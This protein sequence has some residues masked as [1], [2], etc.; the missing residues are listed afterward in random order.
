M[1][2]VPGQVQTN[3][4]K[5]VSNSNTQE[6]QSYRPSSHGIS[7]RAQAPSRMPAKGFGPNPLATWGGLVPD[8]VGAW[9]QPGATGMS[10]AEA[11]ASAGVV[12][13]GAPL[14]LYGPLLGEGGGLTS[15]KIQGAD[16]GTFDGTVASATQRGFKV[17][18]AGFKEANEFYEKHPLR[19]RYKGTTREQVDNI[20]K[21]KGDEWVLKQMLGEDY[22]APDNSGNIQMQDIPTNIK[23]M[24]TEIERAE[25]AR[26]EHLQEQLSAKHQ[27]VKDEVLKEHEADLAQRKAAKEA[28]DE[29]DFRQAEIKATHGPNYRYKGPGAK[30]APK[31]VVPKGTEEIELENFGKPTPKK[32]P[33]IWGTGEP[34]IPG[35]SAYSGPPLPKTASEMFQEQLKPGMTKEELDALRT[36]VTADRK[37]AMRKWLEKGLEE[38]VPLETPGRKIGKIKSALLESEGELVGTHRLEGDKGGAA[39]TPKNPNEGPSKFGGEDPTITVDEGTE[40]DNLLKDRAEEQIPKRPPKP[41]KPG[42]TTEETT[43]EDVPGQKMPE[44]DFR[45]NIGHVK[46]II[47][48]GGVGRKEGVQIG[49]DRGV[50]KHPIGNDKPPVIIDPIIDPPFKPPPDDE[51]KDDEPKDY[52]TV[53]NEHLTSFWKPTKQRGS[54]HDWTHF[55]KDYKEGFYQ[56]GVIPR[57]KW[58]ATKDTNWDPWNDDGKPEDPQNGFAHYNSGRQLLS[59]PPGAAAS[60]L[61]EDNDM[62]A[63]VAKVAGTALASYLFGEYGPSQKETTDA[64]HSAIDQGYSGLKSA[65][66]K[67]YTSVTDYLEERER[68]KVIGQDYVDRYWDVSRDVEERDYDTIMQERQKYIDESDKIVEAEKQERQKHYDDMMEEQAK[69]LEQERKMKEDGE[70]IKQ[71]PKEL[72]YNWA[73]FLAP[74]IEEPEETEP[75]Q[76]TKLTDYYGTPGNRLKTF[77]PKSDSIN[78]PAIPDEVE[79]E[80]SVEPYQIPSG[81]MRDHFPRAGRRP[82][83]GPRKSMRDNYPRRGRRPRGGP[84]PQ[85]QP[86]PPVPPQPFFP[87]LAPE[88]P[89]PPQGGDDPIWHPEPH[90]PAIYRPL[91]Y[92]WKYYFPDSDPFGRHLRY[93]EDDD[94]DDSEISP[95]KPKKVTSNKIG[96]QKDICHYKH[97]TKRCRKKRKL[98]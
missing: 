85:P 38:D 88:N 84:L 58:D 39:I 22:V 81:S 50:D 25:K 2:L 15:G 20:K 1:G 8:V 53:T 67:G 54:F 76:E 64:I 3:S 61:S 29:E 94:D 43:I 26:K 68:Q 52:S 17:N 80:K 60:E 42:T 27:K 56:D 19:H 31:R 69:I 66:E 48:G 93:K 51:P 47:P 97:T 95:E 96:G 37:V 10:K 12:A 71:K 89:L 79:E 14:L 92:A 4:P 63:Q 18:E 57:E 65:M 83:G 36:K 28:K 34:A 87:N 13:F 7:K 33:S 98:S 82:I 78:L 32:T 11:A 9:K 59:W 77:T 44:D 45:P 70:I 23:E 49:V 75:I 21:S 41:S 16:A 6:F 40:I 46:K 5:A 74:K 86:V 73:K 91:K 24:T 30:F 35:E 62:G 72:K 55:K 90:M